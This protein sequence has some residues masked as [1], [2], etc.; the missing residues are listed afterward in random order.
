VTFGT[1][2]SVLLNI[3]KTPRVSRKGAV[4]A[5]A[6]VWH[7]Q[8]TY[9]F[10]GIISFSAATI[11]WLKNQLGLIQSTAEVEALAMSVADSG[12]VYLVP[13]FAGLSAPYWSPDARAAIVGMTAH[14]R[15]GHIVRA[16]L[17]SIA[18]QI[19]DVLDMMR[20][21]SNV[22]L[23]KLHADGGPTRNKFLMQ[24][25]ADMT[26]TELKVSEVAESSAWGA[27][28]GGLLGLGICK[29]L[30][31]L[32]PLPQE[33]TTFRPRM[34]GA[35]VRCHYEGWLAAVKRIL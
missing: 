23:Q 21:D 12:G 33:A 11:E 28:M 10:E 4:T 24:F 2:A 32:T 20:A 30:E 19:R 1:G 16:A 29:S 6:W 8:P 18:Y 22:R 31:E 15:K 7:G 34:D 27:A 26:R 3:G 14:T 25:T 13:A 9:A 35:N 5:L 17:E